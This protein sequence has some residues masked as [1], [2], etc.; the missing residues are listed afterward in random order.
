[1]TEL[2]D[3]RPLK[4]LA[5]RLEDPLKT[6]ILDEPDEIPYD[7]YLIKASIWAR[8]LNNVIERTVS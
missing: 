6:I 3:I 4:K 2:V 8:L 1:M 5:R 7:A